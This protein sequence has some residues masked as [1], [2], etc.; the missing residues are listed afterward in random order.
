MKILE[1]QK[2]LNLWRKN[3][4]E[5]Y[6]ELCKKYRN[7][8][9]LKPGYSEKR[10]LEQQKYRDSRTLLQIKKRKEYAKQ[11]HLDNKQKIINRVK[12]YYFKN[13]DERKKYSKDYYHKNIERDRERRIGYNKIYRKLN[14]E[15]L[16]LYR[17]L[18][19]NRHRELGISW[20]K[21]NKIYLKKQ[22]QKY[23]QKISKGLS[24]NFIINN[25]KVKY[26]KEIIITP[27]LIKIQRIQLEILRMIKNHK[28]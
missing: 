17:K 12:I 19:K 28:L 26:N 8:N 10:R 1:K 9:K 14:V 3:N 24:D 21:K 7:R 25:L 13:I 15:K 27:D 4:P 23:F 5:R 22:K 2:D 6:K 16:N 18:N 11:Y 20:R